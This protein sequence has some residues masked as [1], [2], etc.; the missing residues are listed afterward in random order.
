MLAALHEYSPASCLLTGSK[1]S[2]A[3]HMLPPCVCCAVLFCV[4]D[5]GD[6]TASLDPPSG[7]ESLNHLMLAAGLASARHLRLK[8]LARSSGAVVSGC[9][10]VSRRTSGESESHDA[11]LR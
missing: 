6:A 8:K 2:S 7:S 3:V 5:V 11:S 9:G 10:F 1:R 4:N